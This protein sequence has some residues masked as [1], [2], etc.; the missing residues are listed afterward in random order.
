MDES[1]FKVVAGASD[2]GSPLS[3]QPTF[4]SLE[5]AQA[6]A[7]EFIAEQKRMGGATALGKI[8][9]EEKRPD[10]SVVAHAVG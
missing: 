8:V 4:N 7:R 3:E 1:N 5:E 2:W 6:A 10:G 9:I